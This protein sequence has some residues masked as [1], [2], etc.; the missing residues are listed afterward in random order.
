ML[1][2]WSAIH[3][4]GTINAL[5]CDREL[6]MQLQ[7][8]QMI[9]LRL[10]QAGFKQAV[11]TSHML[12][13]FAGSWVFAYWSLKQPAS[14]SYSVQPYT[15][16]ITSTTCNCKHPCTHAA[17]TAASQLR[18]PHHGHGKVTCFRHTMQ[19]CPEQQYCTSGGAASAPC[20]HTQH[21]SR[22]V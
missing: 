22:G 13:S 21:P 10:S 20:A 18:A 9:N 15:S 2:S 16:R 1:H 3:R 11:H 8:T 12:T 19:A 4:V 14:G 17:E 7:C 5:V 6:V